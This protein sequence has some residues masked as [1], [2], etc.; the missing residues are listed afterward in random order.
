MEKTI[1]TKESQMAL[2]I[3][4][5]SSGYTADIRILDNIQF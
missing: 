5:S 4:P 1:A 3:R 2:T